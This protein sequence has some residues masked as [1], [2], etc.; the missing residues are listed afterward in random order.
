MGTSRTTAT[1]TSCSAGC[2]RGAILF[3][4]YGISTPRLAI[5][6]QAPDDGSSYPASRSVLHGLTR[7]V[8]RE[9]V[10]QRGQ[11]GGLEPDLPRA[12]QRGEEQSVA[13]EEYV[14]DTGDR[15]QT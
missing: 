9:G 2:A 1:R 5:L 3:A 10:G 15:R 14:L 11:W 13:A 12:S 6:Q 4:S 8:G 7:Q